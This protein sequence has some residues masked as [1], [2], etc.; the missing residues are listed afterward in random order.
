MLAP[1]RLFSE[2]AP[3]G[4]TSGRRNEELEEREKG[5]ACSA[6][7]HVPLFYFRGFST[8]YKI[9]EK[10]TRGYSKDDPRGGGA[11]ERE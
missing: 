9:T 8:R 2:T 3:G 1:H 6:S 10:S 7:Q 4:A 11:A 5:E